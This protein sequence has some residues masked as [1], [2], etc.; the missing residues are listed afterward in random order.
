MLVFSYSANGPSYIVLLL[1]TNPSQ[2][3]QCKFCGREGNIT[4]IPKFG[5]PLTGADCEAGQYAPLMSFD[6]RGLEPL[7]YSFGCDQ[8]KVETVSLFCVVR[9]GICYIH[10]I[11]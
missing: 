8:W 6:C 11:L 2:L 5:R 1:L 3:L 10:L 4:M 7:E 9:A